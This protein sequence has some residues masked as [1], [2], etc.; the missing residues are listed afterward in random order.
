MADRTVNINI[1][2][3]VNTA[4]VTK[5]AS[6]AAAAQKATE[7]LRKSTQQY[8]TTASTAGKQAASGLNQVGTAAKTAS[9]NTQSL[10]TSFGGLY[11]AV[12]AVVTAGI[13]R[14]VVDMALGMARLAGNV[15][16]VERAFRRAF[17]NS[18]ATITELREATKGTIT[19]FELMQRTL[20]A[21]NLGVAVEQLP[22]LFEFAAARAQQTG[23]SV[24]YLV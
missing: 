5:A 19:D 21:T 6:A 23:E 10:A 22:K 15:E 9:T 11:T 7:A 1:N 2:Y 3:K 4:D 20:Q 16:G 8:G 13:A 24:D 12:R 14:E 17:P 18:V